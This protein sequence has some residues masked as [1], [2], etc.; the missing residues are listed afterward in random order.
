MK[1]NEFKV[2]FAGDTAVGK[3]SI[4][5]QL[6]FQD[7][8]EFSQTTI[9]ASFITKTIEVDGEDYLTNIWDTAGQERYYSLIPMYFKNAKGIILVYDITCKNSFENL[10]NKWYPDLIKY[11][12]HNNVAIIGNKKDLENK[13][14]VKEKDGRKFAKDFN[15][16]FYEISSKTDYNEI[17]KCFQDLIRNKPFDDF[18]NIEA[19]N[20]NNN[21]KTGYCCTN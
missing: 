17:Y 15:L 12:D 8:D 18:E 10:K 19:I 5:R 7:F 6:I 1:K 9:G 20:L 3:T 16:L 11:I 21:K 13:R 4:N 2:S 14:Q